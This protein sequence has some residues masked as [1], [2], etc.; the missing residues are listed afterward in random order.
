MSRIAR[1]ALECGAAAPLWLFEPQR[2]RRTGQNLQNVTSQKLHRFD[3]RTSSVLRHSPACNAMRGIAGMAFGIS[4]HPYSVAMRWQR[5]WTKW[6]NFGTTFLK[7]FLTQPSRFL[8]KGCPYDV[9]A[10]GHATDCFRKFPKITR[11][12]Q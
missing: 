6:Q 9:R 2:T 10:P 11:A 3:I 8:V 7:K 4:A 1:S 5:I 12:P